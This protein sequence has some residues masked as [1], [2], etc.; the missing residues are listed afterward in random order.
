MTTDVKITKE[1]NISKVVITPEN[2]RELAEKVIQEYNRD[3]QDDSKS[4]SFILT[5]L[6]NTQY[7]GKDIEIFSE[8]GYI[9]NKKIVRIEMNYWNHTKDKV[10]FINLEHDSNQ[11]KIKIWGHDEIW[12]E[13]ILGAIKSITSNWKK[14]ENWIYKYQWPFGIFFSYGFGLFFTNLFSLYSNKKLLPPFDFEDIL[15]YLFVGYFPTSFIILKIKNLYPLV[16]FKIG[17]EHLQKES[18][19]RRKLYLLITL[20]ITPIL[21]SIIFKLLWSEIQKLIGG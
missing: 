19:K 12:T 10:I 1:L 4:I 11:N 16:E 9:Y 21:V 5:S 13:G 20:C 6:D 2:I 14:Q 18:E 3:P 7:T 8:G 15:L 17:P